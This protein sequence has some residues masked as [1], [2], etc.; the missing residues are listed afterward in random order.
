MQGGKVTI[1]GG[2]LAGCE[3]ARQLLSGGVHVT[4]HEMRPLRLSPAHKSPTL[5]ELVCSNS[6]RSAEIS[7]AAGLLKEE[8]RRLRSVVIEAADAAA[9]PA[10]KALAVDRDQFSARVEETL[11][12]HQDLTVVRGEV[13]EIPEGEIVLIASGPLTSDALAEKITGL[14]G[15]GYL[16]F[17]D[18]ISPIVD[19]ATIDLK[20]TFRASRYREGEGD[21]LNCPLTAG[22]Y[23]RFHRAL[24]GGRQVPLRDFEDA[25]FFEG[26]LPVEVMASRGAETLRFGPMKPV[27]LVDPA[28]GKKP[29]AVVQL[30]PENRD[31]R[32][33]NLVGFQT[34]LAWPEQARIFRMIPG[35]ERADFLRFGSVH[36]N[37]YIN[38]PALL[39]KTL[40][41]RTQGN[42]YFAGQIIGVEGYIESAAMGLLAGISIGCRL[43]GKEFNPP[44]ATTGLGALLRHVIGSDPENFQPMN[45]NFGL[46]EPLPGKVGKRSRGAHYAERALADLEDWS[47]KAGLH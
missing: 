16:Y 8:M 17:Y 37:T 21:Y 43:A 11:L 4:L 45:V 44:P 35:L 22:E 40:C 13:R 39:E 19:A 12:N 38:S 1:I 20:K 27:G 23:E 30:R 3:A 14:T 33:Y 15:S 5:A 2:G 29:H 36:R 26:C 28:T 47:R 24:L 9:I 42:I 25:K 32:A 34:K 41:L 7:T 46:F 18:A 6:F 10:G 31:C